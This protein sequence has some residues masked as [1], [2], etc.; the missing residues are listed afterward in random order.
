M[1]AAA[2]WGGGQ[3]PPNIFISIISF[4]FFY[5][6]KHIQH[7]IEHISN[8]RAPNEETYLSITSDVNKY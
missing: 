2:C 3:G 1:P 7:L 4:S 5:V 6:S 8:D